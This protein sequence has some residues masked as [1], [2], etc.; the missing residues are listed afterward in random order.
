[1]VTYGNK[2]PFS[3]EAQDHWWIYVYFIGP[4]ARAYSRI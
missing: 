1:M 2:K 3:D 4:R